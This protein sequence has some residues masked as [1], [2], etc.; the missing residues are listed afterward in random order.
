MSN[1]GLLKIISNKTGK[2]SMIMVD[3][4]QLNAL[5]KQYVH[6]HYICRNQHTSSQIET[7]LLT[8]LFFLTNIPM[9]T[10]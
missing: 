4:F 2:W 7:I 5:R 8:R 3:G 10:H 9:A 6:H 1:N